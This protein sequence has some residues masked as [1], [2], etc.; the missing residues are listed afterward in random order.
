[1]FEDVDVLLLVVVVVCRDSKEVPDVVA[2]IGVTEWVWWL[3]WWW[4]Q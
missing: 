4:W 3:W 1:M 2:T